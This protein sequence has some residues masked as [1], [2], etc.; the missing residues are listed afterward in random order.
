MLWS[1]SSSRQMFSFLRLRFL[2]NLLLLWTLYFF[3]SVFLKTHCLRFLSQCRRRRF[4][5]FLLLT[6]CQICNKSAKNVRNIFN[7]LFLSFFELFKSVLLT[8][9]KARMLECLAVWTTSC[10]T[11]SCLFSLI[12]KFLVIVSDNI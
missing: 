12:Q 1:L 6:V 5:R 2:S 4:E 8:V 10:R 7:S 11:W 9:C 3:F